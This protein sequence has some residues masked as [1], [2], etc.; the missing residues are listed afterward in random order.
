MPPA[1]PR[2]PLLGVRDRADVGRRVGGGVA[3]GERHLRGEREHERIDVAECEGEPQVARDLH[4][5]AAGADDRRRD[6]GR[7]RAGATA[8]GPRRPAPARRGQHCV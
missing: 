8:A 2:S 1:R 5:R 3:D 6:G 4:G 7:P